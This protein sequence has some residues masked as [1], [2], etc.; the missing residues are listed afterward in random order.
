MNRL[1][2]R[3]MIAAA[4]C[5]GLAMILLFSCSGMNKPM[6]SPKFNIPGA[7]YVGMTTCSA[8]HEERVKNFQYTEHARYL[9]GEK[10]GVEF[11]GCEGCHGPGS[12]HVEAGGGRGVKIINPE[13]NPSPCFQCHLDVRASFNLQYH[14][15]VPEDFM[16]CTMCHNPHGEHIYSP[17][18]TL[19]VRQNVTHYQICYQC[20]KD[21]ARPHVYEHLA[22]REGCPTCHHPHG[23]INDKLLIDRD[24]NLCIRC[25]AQMSAPG[26]IFMGDVNHSSFLTR[27]PCWSAGCH[28]AIHGSNMSDK[29]RY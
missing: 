27:G 7:E 24:A 8:C 13:N 18:G 17:K 16:N 21:Q 6:V 26:T 19:V 2:N 25:H 4:G 29:L 28:T 1:S 9:V 20:H 22:L 23:S 3:L 12:L 10:D 11:P 15:P 14:H 5:L